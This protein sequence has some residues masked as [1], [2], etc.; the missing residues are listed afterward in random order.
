MWCWHN[1]SRGRQR[2]GTVVM[3]AQ[4]TVTHSRSSQWS[5]RRSATSLGEVCD[6]EQRSDTGGAAEELTSPSGTSGRYGLREGKRSGPW[7]Q[8]G[9]T[10]RGAGYPAEVLAG[11]LGRN[12]TTVL[13]LGS[14]LI[15]QTGQEYRAN[16][17]VLILTVATGG[18]KTPDS[19]QDCGRG[20]AVTLRQTQPP[21]L[22]KG[23]ER[24]DCRL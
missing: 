20:L 9:A 1:E 4:S 19:T 23:Q 13:S 10:K 22:F 8:S 15:D 11:S 24:K 6:E 18:S 7:Q 3:N 14:S 21:V 5:P 2:W 16:V 12:L 17:A